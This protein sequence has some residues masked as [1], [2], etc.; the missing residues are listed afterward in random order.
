MNSISPSITKDDDYLENH[1]KQVKV[2]RLEKEIDGL[3]YELY[4][5]TPGEIEIVENFNKKSK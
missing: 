1:S 3:V 4:D 5:L 2:K